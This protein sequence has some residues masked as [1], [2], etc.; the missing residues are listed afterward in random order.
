MH[1]LEP[2]L[3]PLP[4]IIVPKVSLSFVY[5][6]FLQKSGIVTKINRFPNKDVKPPIGSLNFVGQSRPHTTL[7][8]FPNFY[9]SV[10]SNLAILP[11][12]LIM[13]D[14]QLSAV[15]ASRQ[16]RSMYRRLVT[17]PS[18]SIDFSSNDFLG[19][20]RSAVFKQLFLSEL[21]KFS[22]PPLGSTGSRLLDGNSSYAEDLE[23]FI[24][25][26]H[27]AETALLFNSGFDANSGFFGC[28]PRPGD[29]VLYDEYIH[30]SVHEGM[31]VSRA[32]V[33]RAF[34]HN[35][36]RELEAIV[37]EIVEEDRGNEAERRNVFVAV[38]TVYSMDGDVAP[39]GEIVEIVKRWWP[40]R[41]NG[42][43]VVDEVRCA[44]SF[45]SPR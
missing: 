16:H 14:A 23:S 19:L 6:S 39:L 25:R 9:P 45:S 28:V 35:D 31:R 1:N 29:V 37:R 33:R 8:N 11:I 3:R 42:Y 21:A 12:S 5:F 7:D 4:L 15:L 43:I 30:A 44:L 10:I 26:F 17:N 20:S 38:E 2:S 36:V 34:K 18:T 22:H 40:N 32:G 41:E 13:L 24:A 27:N